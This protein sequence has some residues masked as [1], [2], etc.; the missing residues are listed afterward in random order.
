MPSFSTEQAKA[1]IHAAPTLLW[2]Q[3][4]IFSQFPSQVQARFQILWGFAF[5]CGLGVS[6]NFQVTLRV[7][8][9]CQVSLACHFS[10]PLIVVVIDGLHELMKIQQHDGS[11]MVHHLVFD[12]TGQ[13]FIGLPEKGMVIPLY[14]GLVMLLATT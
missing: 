5:G 3:L 9:T 7:N 1:V 13:A 8:P 14:V 4:A 11:V 2:G 6:G 12:T 10:L